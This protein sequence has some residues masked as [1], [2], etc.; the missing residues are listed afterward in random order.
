MK[1]APLIKRIPNPFDSS[2]QA[3]LVRMGILTSDSQI[4]QKAIG[5]AVSYVYI[6]IAYIA[7]GGSAP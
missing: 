5:T 1:T 4:N 6:Y 7:Q 3:R 2:T